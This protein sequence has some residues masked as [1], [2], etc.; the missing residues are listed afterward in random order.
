MLNPR[1]RVSGDQDSLSDCTKIQEL[2]QVKS[3]KGRGKLPGRVLRTEVRGFAVWSC[4]SHTVWSGI[5]LVG[6]GVW[7]G[8]VWWFCQS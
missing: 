1:G 7:F 8:L 5:T 2:V 4:E 3:K 6:K